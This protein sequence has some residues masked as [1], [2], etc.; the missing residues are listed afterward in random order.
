M[1]ISINWATKVISVP[2]AD[3]T[4]VGGTLYEH[5]TNAFRL[6]LKGLEDD[7]AGMAFERTNKHNTEV[8]VAGQT[9]ARTIEIINGYSV[10]YED[11]A[12]SVRL[13][14][15][16]NNIWD[17]Q[18]GILVQNQV[19]VI[20]TNSAG[21]IVVSTGSG[22]SA[23]QDARLSA[24]EQNE[25]QA[26]YH[27][28]VSLDPTSAHTGT[29][30]PVGNRANPVNNLPDAVSIA[31]ARGF[32]TL[33]L[34]GTVTLDTGSDLTGF[35][36]QGRSL[37]VTDVTINASA[38]V[39]GCTVRDC[40]VSG[41]LDGD[42]LIERC[43]IHDLDYV[44]GNVI[45][46]A[47]NGTITL[48]GSTQANILD[49]WSNVAGTATP[50]IDCG[51]SGRDLGVRN[52]NGGLTLRNKTGAGDNVSVDM[53]SGHLILDATLT[54][55]QVVARGIGTLTDNSGGATVVQDNFISAGGLSNTQHGMLMEQWRLRGCDMGASTV[56]RQT[57]GK[58]YRIEVGGLTVNISE[59]VEGGDVTLSRS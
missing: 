59:P 50:I 51:G 49:C 23:E 12:Y 8:T 35:T 46:C 29:N 15:S 41:T 56:I 6:G 37:S 40:Q 10:E 57:D 32:K 1:A 20:P 54:A 34:V 5:D 14:G 36:L 45:Q 52:Y 43:I 24:I 27:L 3:L 26:S 42:T 4:L 21:L 22:L 17:I 33:Y 9:Y 28:G 30:Y 16:N 25:Q 11:G 39:S 44:E 19:Q 58:P 31:N 48:G 53:N 7:E 18:N 47:L 38:L 2:K 55:G 13:T